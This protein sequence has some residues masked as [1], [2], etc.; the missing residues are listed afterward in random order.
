MQADLYNGRR[1]WWLLLLNMGK[2][3]CKQKL[4]Q[5]RTALIAAM[6]A[7]SHCKQPL[8]IYQR[9]SVNVDYC[10]VP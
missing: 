5:H 7:V 10:D 2:K 8:K 9:D 3:H 6:K 1:W 4:L